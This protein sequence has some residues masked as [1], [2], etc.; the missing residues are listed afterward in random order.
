MSSQ[1]IQVVR[2]EL[3]S[4]N[5]LVD[6]LFHLFNIN[7]VKQS[8]WSNN[9][10]I[11]LVHLVFK[12]ECFMRTV[13]LWPY[14]ERE[15]EPMSMFISHKALLNT[16][17]WLSPEYYIPTISY[18]ATINCRGC[19]V[20]GHYNTGGWSYFFV[21]SSAFNYQLFRLLQID[22]RLFVEEIGN[23]IS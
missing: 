17:I 22:W 13:P 12:S 19:G 8:I 7:I 18:V 15:I 20:D 1:V 10:N 21:Q 23:K 2:Q 3:V 9:N 4:G 11:I 6:N 14:L 16:S 5:I